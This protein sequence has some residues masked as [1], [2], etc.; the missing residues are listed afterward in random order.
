MSWVADFRK[1]IMRGSVIDLAIGVVMGTAFTA[2]VN[3]LVDD[4]IMPIVGGIIGVDF[5]SLSF[6]FNG[7]TI[8][9]GN[10]LQALINFLIIALF[11]FFA[12]RWM[13]RLSESMGLDASGLEGIVPDGEEEPEPEPEPEPSD[14]VVLLT[15]IR[16]LLVKQAEN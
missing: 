15:E 1:F 7:S 14:E 3:S 13:I 2:I 11:I 12:I 16:D 5:T 8:A 10:F 4:I 9:Y 6:Q